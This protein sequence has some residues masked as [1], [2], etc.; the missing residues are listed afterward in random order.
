[1][2]TRPLQI[3]EQGGREHHPFVNSRSVSKVGIDQIRRCPLQCTLAIGVNPTFWQLYI[4]VHER[5]VHTDLQILQDSFAK[6]NLDAGSQTILCVSEGMDGGTTGQRL[7]AL[8][9]SI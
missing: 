7:Y 6:L 8:Y 2:D 9:R 4:R 3:I 5:T 1:M